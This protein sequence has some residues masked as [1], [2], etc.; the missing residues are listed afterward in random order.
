MKR[1]GIVCALAVEARH[2]C[3]VP[4]PPGA[5]ATL[6]DGSLLTIS[7][8]GGAAATR[9]AHALLGAGATALA[10]WGMAGGLDPSLGA[11]AIILPDEIMAPGGATVATTLRWRDQ[12]CLTLTALQPVVLGRLLS[13]ATVIASVAEKSALFAATGAVAVDMESAAVAGAAHAQQLPFIA[14]RVIVDGATDALPGSVGAA[15]GADG[16]LRPW[17]LAAA[18]ARTP[19]DLML[20]P[21]LARRYRTA[22]RRLAAVAGVS[23][24]QAYAAAGAAQRGAS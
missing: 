18:L 2:L 1:V 8:M 19:A 15:S 23:L 12:L 4:P 21:G 7:G 5:I 13:S 6:P 9:G 10:S 24:Q 20:L 17:R 22:S 11:G 3:P 16:R 14:V